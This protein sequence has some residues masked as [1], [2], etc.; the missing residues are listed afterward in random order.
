MSA[1]VQISKALI[2]DTAAA[3]VRSVYADLSNVEKFKT[4]LDTVSVSTLESTYGYSTTDANVL[5]SAVTELADLAAIFRG[6]APTL[7][8]PHDYRT[9][10]KQLIGVGLY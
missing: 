7:S 5:K 1:G 3:I 8:L 6:V 9:F 2:D 10:A 4:W